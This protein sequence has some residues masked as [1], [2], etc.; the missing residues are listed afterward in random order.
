MHCADDR[1]LRKVF[2]HFGDLRSKGHLLKRTNQDLMGKFILGQR[3]QDGY[4]M[5]KC[6]TDF[7]LAVLLATKAE[8]S[9]K[10]RANRP[11]IGAI[12]PSSVEMVRDISERL[13][14]LESTKNRGPHPDERNYS[15][16]TEGDLNCVFCGRK[17]HAQ[18]DDPYR[19]SQKCSYCS[20][21][22]QFQRVSLVN[23]IWA[24]ADKILVHSV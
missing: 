11:K 16:H 8:S 1:A 21:M 18:K 3:D 12:H 13:R 5:D 15:R 4:V 22:G 9:E 10:F 7:D 14:A 6:P 2:F 23:A 19:V 20:K 17:G 24:V